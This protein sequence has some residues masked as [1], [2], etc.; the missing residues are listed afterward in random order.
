MAL[1]AP[2]ANFKPAPAVIVP[3][4]KAP[5]AQISDLNAPFR[6][7]SLY[8][9]PTDWT[10]GIPSLYSPPPS[11]VSPSAPVAENPASCFELQCIPPAPLSDLDSDMAY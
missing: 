3:W 10:L 9:D 5:T 7:S 6:P 8:I 4:P 11:S 2:W 1:S